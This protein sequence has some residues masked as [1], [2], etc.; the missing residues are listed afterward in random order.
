MDRMM[1]LIDREEALSRVGHDE[2]LL[3]ELAMLFLGEYPV[4]LQELDEAVASGNTQLLERSAHALKGSVANFGAAPVVN[5][6]LELE[7]MGRSGNMDGAVDSLHRLH[8]TLD[9]LKAELLALA[10]PQA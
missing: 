7:K 2:E 3:A 6:A 5:H 4:S 9:S 1:A 8:E 10:T